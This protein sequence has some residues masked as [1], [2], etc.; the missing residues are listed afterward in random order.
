MSLPAVKKP[1]LEAME[2]A[3][4]LA[5]PVIMV[6]STLFLI[7]RRT[8]AATPGRGGSMI[9]TN[10]TNVRAWACGQEQGGERRGGCEEVR[11]LGRER[12]A[13]GAGRRLWRSHP[14]N[15][16]ARRGPRTSMSCP[17]AT[18]TT[19]RPRAAS[20]PA[21][22]MAASR[23]AAD[24]GAGGTPSPLNAVAERSSTASVM[25]FTKKVSCDWG[26]GEDEWR[27]GA[28]RGWRGVAPCPPRR[29]KAGPWR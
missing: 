7:S 6:T 26:T 10:P 2:H 19:R 3:V 20:S 14:S 9:P 21:C 27:R 13:V 24:S 8:L 22:C 16:R 11:R 5:S 12:R 4:S 25:P 28:G 23:S 29:G 17:Y 1:R 18:A 15:D